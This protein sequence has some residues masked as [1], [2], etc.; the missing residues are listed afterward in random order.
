MTA[1]L[2]APLAVP[3]LCWGSFIPQR[4]ISANTA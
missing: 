3:D 4:A 1:L 2:I